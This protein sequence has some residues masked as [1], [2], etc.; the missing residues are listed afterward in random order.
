MDPLVP[1]GVLGSPETVAPG[2]IE[3]AKAANAL[4]DRRVRDEEGR[5]AFL[6]EGVDRVERL[7]GG[8]S[9]EADEFV[10]LLEPDERVGEPVRGSAEAGGDGV[11]A[12]FTLRREQ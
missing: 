1:C 6:G 2:R 9:L 12:V 3:R 4:G 8:A 7:G 10:R 5:E 11:G